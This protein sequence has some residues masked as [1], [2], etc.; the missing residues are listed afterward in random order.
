MKELIINSTKT[1]YYLFKRLCELMLNSQLEE[2]NKRWLIV[3][4]NYKENCGLINDLSKIFLTKVIKYKRT[5]Q[6]QAGRNVAGN[7]FMK[8]KV[9]K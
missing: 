3:E 9:F 2:E 8:I 7:L 5:N 4:I 1:K 6:K